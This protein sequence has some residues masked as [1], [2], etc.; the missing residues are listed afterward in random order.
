MNLPQQA[1]IDNIL[2]CKFPVANKDKKT[3]GKV[4]QKAGYI[5]EIPAFEY[6]H[7]GWIGEFLIIIQQTISY[8]NKAS[9]TIGMTI[10]AIEPFPQKNIYSS[11]HK[12]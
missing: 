5:I 8:Y 7:G 3:A 9:H 10:K 2:L 12:E 4:S 6:T 11:K 1:K